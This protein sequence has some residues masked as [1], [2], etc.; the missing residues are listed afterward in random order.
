MD[1]AIITAKDLAEQRRHYAGDGVIA[2]PGLVPPEIAAALI[3]QIM[4]EAA[5]GASGFAPPPGDANAVHGSALQ[6]QGARCPSLRSFHWGLTP[7]LRVITG[8]DLIPSHS[9]FRINS[10]DAK[11]R[12][13]TDKPRFEHALSLTLAYSDDR[14]WSFEVALDDQRA[15]SAEFDWAARPHRRFDMAVGDAVLYRGYDRAHARTTP[16]PNGSSAHAFLF[17]VDRAGPRGEVR[18]AGSL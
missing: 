9:F 17:W 10:R 2:L 11:L 12:I 18:F 16:N 4:R 6:T 13:H 14:S 5:D 8:L 1:R 7:A 15:A 3:A